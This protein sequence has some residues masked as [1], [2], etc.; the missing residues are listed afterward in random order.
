MKFACFFF[1]TEPCWIKFFLGPLEA[2]R[3]RPE[4][5]ASIVRRLSL[6]LT[7]FSCILVV[8]RKNKLW[9]PGPFSKRKMK[10]TRTFGW[11]APATLRVRG[12]IVRML[13]LPLR[14]VHWANS[15]WRQ[16]N[17]RTDTLKTEEELIT[18]KVWKNSNFFYRCAVWHCP[19]H[20]QHLRATFLQQFASA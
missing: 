15:I 9:F 11:G 8:D 3:T 10:C 1:S 16:T 18:R 12:V 5:G 19:F 2:P 4:H 7:R 17:R 6:W 20:T 13:Y 14:K